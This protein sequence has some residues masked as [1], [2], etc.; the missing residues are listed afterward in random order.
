MMNRALNIDPSIFRAVKWLEIFNGMMVSKFGRT[1]S[2]AERTKYW[3]FLVDSLHKAE[4]E[5]DP[6][7]RLVA[8]VGVAEKAGMSGLLPPQPYVDMMRQVGEN[9]QIRMHIEPPKVQVNDEQI[10]KIVS[11]AIAF[12]PGVDK[13]GVS[14]LPVGVREFLIH[15][16][17]LQLRNANEPNVGDWVHRSGELKNWDKDFNDLAEEL[18]SK[19]GLTTKERD[20]L[21]LAVAE[22]SSRREEM[23]IAAMQNFVKDLEENGLAGITERMQQMHE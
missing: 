12:L 4:S 10:P 21:E 7:T 5:S 22:E 2:S 8:V 19:L 3:G 18:A 17:C 20:A 1:Y 23:K 14:P 11:E 13:K 9:V 16:V 15:T 6:V